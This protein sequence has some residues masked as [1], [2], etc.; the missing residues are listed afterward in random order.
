MATTV[1]TCS[2]PDCE[3]PATSKVAAPWSYGSFRELKTFGYSCP[4][5]TEAVLD[6]AERR[7]KPRQLDEGETLGKIDPFEL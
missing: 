5:H 3:Q 1:V 4:I 7:P 6:H 2:I